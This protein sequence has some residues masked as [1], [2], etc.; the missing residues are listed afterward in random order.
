MI[1]LCAHFFLVALNVIGRT[2]TDDE[3]LFLSR[4][5]TFVL[6]HKISFHFYFEGNVTKDETDIST[7]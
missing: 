6:H 5:K 7:G 3:I 4:G 2:V 1:C